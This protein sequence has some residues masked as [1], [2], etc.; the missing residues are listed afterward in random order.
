MQRPLESPWFTTSEEAVTMAAVMKPAFHKLVGLG[1]GGGWLG[2]CGS[3]GGGDDGGGDGGG[4]E[5]GGEGGGK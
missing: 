5:G 1:G 2:G 3:D 4:G